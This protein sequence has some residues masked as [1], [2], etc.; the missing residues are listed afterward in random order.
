MNWKIF[1]VPI[2][3]AAV[4]AGLIALLFIGIPSRHKLVLKAY[5][6]D[7]I[8]LRAGAPVRLAGVD[9]GYVKTVRVR[10]ELRECPVEVTMVLVPPYE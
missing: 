1:R 7:G 8:D 4:C 2:L 5:F 6:A 10:P 9:L 3:I